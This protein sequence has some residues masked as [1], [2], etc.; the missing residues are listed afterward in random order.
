MDKVHLSPKQDAVDMVK[1]WRV[2]KMRRDWSKFFQTSA[3]ASETPLT[4]GERKLAL[5]WIPA[6][7]IALIIC[8]LL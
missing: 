1:Y 5:V 2:E 3:E 6:L 8:A 4:E 7:I